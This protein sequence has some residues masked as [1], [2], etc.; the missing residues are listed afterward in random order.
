MFATLLKQTPKQ[1]FPCEICNLFKNT[2]FD[3]TPPVAVPGW[4]LVHSEAVLRRCSVK[5][6]FL[7]ISQNSLEN[8]RTGIFCFVEYLWTAAPE[9]Y[10]RKKTHYNTCRISPQ[11][12]HTLSFVFKH[13]HPF[14]SLMMI[15]Y[16]KQYLSNIWSSIDKNVNWETE[17][18]FNKSI[19][20]GGCHTISF[21]L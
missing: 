1:V 7:K 15:V 16:T 6:M 17:T 8:I 13:K 12:E 4:H 2:F 19:A 14:F 10:K 3:R 21:I 18:E 5:K 20:F 9:H 11:Y